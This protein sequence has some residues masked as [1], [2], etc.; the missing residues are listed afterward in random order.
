MKRTKTNKMVNIDCKIHE[1]NS[2]WTFLTLILL[3]SFYN[4]YLKIFFFFFFTFYVWYCGGSWHASINF[5]NKINSYV[6]SDD[7]S[8]SFQSRIEWCYSSNHDIILLLKSRF[9]LKWYWLLAIYHHINSMDTRIQAKYD[10]V[11]IWTE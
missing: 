4:F 1:K 3:S 6:K 2:N 11:H 10:V 9:R 5:L 8:I 7:F